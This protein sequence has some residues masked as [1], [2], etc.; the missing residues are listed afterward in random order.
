MNIPKVNSRVHETTR[1][2]YLAIPRNRQGRGNL[3][4]YSEAEIRAAT[5]LSYPHGARFIPG[6]VSESASVAGDVEGCP[7]QRRP[8][9]EQ[10]GGGLAQSNSPACVPDGYVI[11]LAQI[12]REKPSVPSK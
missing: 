8:D 3:F 6:C 9:I 4:G 11:G 2:Q 1:Q 5:L 12:G 7:Y 10:S